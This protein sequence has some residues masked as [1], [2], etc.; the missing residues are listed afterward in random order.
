MPPVLPAALGVCSLA[1]MAL[2]W[3]D[4]RSKM[5][6]EKRTLSSLLSQYLAVKA[7][8]WLGRRQRRQLD[9]DTVNVKRV[10][11]ETLLKRLSRNADTS[12]G[13]LYDFGSI[14]GEKTQES[15]EKVA[16]VVLGSSVRTP[17]CWN[18]H[19]DTLMCPLSF[20]DVTYH[21]YSW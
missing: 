9:G 2:V 11:E 15:V 20:C 14:R 10:Q 18:T 5:R 13:R 8:G 6:G 12:Y 19:S 21:F 1:G 17:V 16:Y 4:M 3:R 7:V